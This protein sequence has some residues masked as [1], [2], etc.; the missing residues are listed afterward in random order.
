MAFSWHLLNTT[1][2]DICQTTP[3]LVEPRRKPLDIVYDM[4]V[5]RKSIPR[6]KW[7]WQLQKKKKKKRGKRLILSPGVIPKKKLCA[8]SVI[9]IE[10]F[11][12]KCFL[13][14]WFFLFDFPR[15]R[16]NTSPKLTSFLQEQFK[17][18]QK[19]FVSTNIV[20]CR[21]N[22]LPHVIPVDRMRLVKPSCRLVKSH[23]KV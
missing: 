9:V 12:D 23:W 2:Q 5:K 19:C 7:V 3:C 8:R 10:S 13:S 11:R 21:F 4:N 20:S 1:L 6:N 15:K 17:I 22:E 14:R 18:L 16:M